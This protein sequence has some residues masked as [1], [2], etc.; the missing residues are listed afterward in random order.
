MRLLV[1]LFCMT[2]AEYLVRHADHALR[3]ASQAMPI[4]IVDG[5]RGVGKTTSAK[6]LASSVVSLPADLARLE[7]DAEDLLRTLEPPVL[8][9]EWQL[10]GVDLLW[11]LKRIVD[12]EPIP[13]R[14]LL[15]GSVEPATYGPTYPLIGRAAVVAMRPMTRAELDGRGDAP[16]WTERMVAGQRPSPSAGRA[17]AFDWSWL[18]TTGFP[19]AREMVDAALFLDGYAAVVAQRAG[20]EGRDASRLGRALRVLATLE[21]QAVPD[22]RIWE[23]A[24]L[25]KTTWKAYDD[26][27]ARTHLSV[28][29]PAFESNRL[30][31]LTS[32]PKR[33]LADVALALRLA[34]L[35]PPAAGGDLTDLGA[36]LES[37]VVQQ[38]R[39]QID[40][41]GGHALHL[42][43][44]SNEREIDVVV[45]FGNAVFAIEVKATT[46]PKP[47]AAQ[48][49]AWLR[50]GIGE[51][52]AGGF[53]A[54]TGGDTYLLADDIW[55]IPIESICTAHPQP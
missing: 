19:A 53:V 38:L 10:A 23:A 48:H 18:T 29:L 43:T 6:R 44:G 35:E 20:D 36:Y 46:S 24:D 12:D 27:L 8:I 11:T 4:V 3:S 52:F 42:R 49:I 39:P 5:P 30:K 28:P 25:N 40:G 34:G 2:D 26:L 21:S 55:A 50:D 45:E 14:F 13:G 31:R 33:H 47:S 41:I 51:R 32:Y 15:A 1:I 54:H 9:D 7:A 16:T 17:G 22:Q 37:F